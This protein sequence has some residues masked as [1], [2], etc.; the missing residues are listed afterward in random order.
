MAL[1]AARGPVVVLTRKC[2]SR[3]APNFSIVALCFCQSSTLRGDA[4]GRSFLF[5]GFI[6]L[7]TTN[8]SGAENGSGRSKSALTKLK[9]AV[10]APSPSARLIT[11][12]TVKAGR[13]NKLRR[14]ILISLSRVSTTHLLRATPGTRCATAFHSG[15]SVE[16]ALRCAVLDLQCGLLLTFTANSTKNRR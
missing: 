4:V 9:I 16:K 1:E 7:N 3:H 15:R 6:S 13:F 10:F 8:R 2:Q 12:T 11:A 14:L 5:S